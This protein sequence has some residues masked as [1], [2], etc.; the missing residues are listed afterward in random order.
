[1]AHTDFLVVIQDIYRSLLNAVE[2]LQAQGAII[3]EVIGAVK[4]V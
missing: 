3:L 2:G 4:C 1:M